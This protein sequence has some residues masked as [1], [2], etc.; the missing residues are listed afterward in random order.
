MNLEKA[1]RPV[2]VPIVLGLTLIL[3]LPRT[4]AA[5]K[6]GDWSV[7]VGGGVASLPKYP[8]ADQQK[9]QAIP[10]ISAR[11]RRFFVGDAPGSGTPAG[12]GVFLH[13]DEH[14]KV[15]AAL[16]GDLYSSRKERDDRRHLRGLGDIKGAARGGIFAS[17]TLDWFSLHGGAFYDLKSH[18]GAT[19]TLGAGARYSPFDRLVLTAGPDVV[20]ANRQ[21][22]Q[23]F[24]GVTA[25]QAMRSGYPEY[26]PKGGVPLIRFSLAANYQL[27]T[28]WSLGAA[29][30]AGRLEGD[31][32][33]S[34][35]VRNKN[36]TLVGVFAVYKFR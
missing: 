1:V 8:G 3:Q 9:I 15:G 23:T 30:S 5:D 14:W 24:F 33:R 7:A 29:A 36:Q 18:Q 34:P 10:I 12:L 2:F 25:L 21:Y 11:Y 35:I 31:A 17:Y 32:A 4:L 22:V 13:E 27:N 19:A 20:F 6:K 16:G 26:T 28:R